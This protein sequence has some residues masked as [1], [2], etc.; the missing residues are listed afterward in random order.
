MSKRFSYVTAAEA[1]SII[2]DMLDISPLSSEGIPLDEAYDRVLAKAILSPQNLPL[3]DVSHFD[4]YAIQSRDSKQASVKNPIHLS[5]IER[6][7]PGQLPTREV[8]SGEACYV[9]TGSFLPSGADTV[10]AV[11]ATKML[12]KGHIEIRSFVKLNAHVIRCG[13]DVKQGAILF[14]EGHKI[15]A[16]DLN[17]LAALH[18]NHLDVF[19][20]PQVAVICVS[21]ELTD[22]I[23]EPPAGQVINSHRYAITAMVAASG[24]ITKY[25][26]IAPDDKIAIKKKIKTTVNR[27]DL[28]LIIGGSSM[29]NKD[30]TAEAITS[31][32]S[33]G[34]I[35][36]GIK[37]KP[38]RVSGF[39][40]VH[41][42]PIVLLPRLCHSMV[43][44]F[45]TIARPLILVLSGRSVTDAELTVRARL[46]KPIRFTSFIPFEHVTFI[47]VYRSA[48]GYQADPCVGASS[49][50]NALARANAFMI[51][52]P[53][54]SFVTVGETVE[55]QLLPSLF[56]FNDFF[57]TRSSLGALHGNTITD[58]ATTKFKMS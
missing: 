2:T 36:H 42:T 58:S 19:K 8:H 12:H 7:Y 37:R 31:A 9:T 16:Q 10:V 14:C 29:G 43:V 44:G 32:G 41:G 35:F 5:V 25:F 49:S 27:T 47:N 40:I 18:I 52:P 28:V 23:E 22:N 51:T 30:V 48:R 53:H 26:G 4:G 20:K 15:R 50:Y 34:I 13:S 21:D 24:G 55:V 54:T 1:F 45:H 33:P 6:L 46:T 56:S 3:H 17:L 39:A 38:G 57:T 11:E